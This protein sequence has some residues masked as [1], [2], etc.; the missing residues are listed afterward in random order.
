MLA[1]VPGLPRVDHTL[2]VML[3]DQIIFMTKVRTPAGKR[4]ACLIGS[5][6]NAVLS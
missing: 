4:A 3:V 1:A 6:P 5:Q 2:G